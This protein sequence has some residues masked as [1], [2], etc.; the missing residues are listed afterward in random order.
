MAY[1]N[2]NHRLGSK[3]AALGEKL[4]QESRDLNLGLANA[5]FN[6]AHVAVQGKLESLGKTLNEILFVRTELIL[7]GERRQRRT[8]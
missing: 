7:A 3:L 5:D 8:M 2:Y 4:E 1:I 6:A